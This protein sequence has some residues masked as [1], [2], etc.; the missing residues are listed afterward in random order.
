MSSS[1][2]D[3]RGADAVGGADT[4]RTPDDD[5]HDDAGL[6][7]CR[8]HGFPL[9]CSRCGELWRELLEPMLPWA[10]RKR[11]RPEDENGGT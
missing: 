6:R 4:V 8:R 10:P 11:R 3:V 7:R 2:D 1:G 9:P 5:P